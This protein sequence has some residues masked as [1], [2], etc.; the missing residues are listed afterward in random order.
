[1]NN[2]KQ[3]PVVIEFLPGSTLKHPEIALNNDDPHYR[4]NPQ[5]TVHFSNGAQISVPAD[6]IVLHEYTDKQV[7]IG[8]GGM[9]YEGIENDQLVFWRVKD[10]FPEEELHPQR[11]MKFTID[12][13]L[14]SRIQIHGTQ[15]WPRSAAKTKT[16]QPLTC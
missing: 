10:L 11:E 15:V 14:V 4:V 7:R 8:L 2:A 3:P 5:S 6:Q 9:S 13:N 16:S 12:L 1:M